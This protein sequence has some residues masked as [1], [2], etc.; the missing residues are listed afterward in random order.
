MI[1]LLIILCHYLVVEMMIETI[2]K[3]FVDRVTAVNE[4]VRD[5]QSG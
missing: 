3:H 5:G 4:I 2:Y 1:L